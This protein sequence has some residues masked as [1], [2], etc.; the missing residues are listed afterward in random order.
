MVMNEGRGT[1]QIAL[2]VAEFQMENSLS[3]AH[4]QTMEQTAAKIVGI[5]MYVA[6]A[7]FVALTIGYIAHYDFGISRLDIRM[8]AL[9]GASTFAVIVVLLLATEFYEKL[10]KPK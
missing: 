2:L 10:R 1:Q 5:L 9:I 7:A 6:I 4:T 3:R 8:S